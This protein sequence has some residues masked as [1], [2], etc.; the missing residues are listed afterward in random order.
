[1]VRSFVISRRYTRIG[2]VLFNTRAFKIF[3]FNSHY[4]KRGVIRAINGIRYP[5]GGTRLGNA[6]RYTWIHLFRTNRR[7]ARK[8]LFVLTDGKSQDRVG[9][10][11]SHLRRTGVEIH[12]MG[13]GRR[14]SVKQLRRVATDSRHI[15]TSGF[16]TMRNII[17]IIKKRICRGMLSFHQVLWSIICITTWKTL[18]QQS[19]M[20]R[21]KIHALQNRYSTKQD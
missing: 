21:H 3:G 2:A 14:Y 17:R 9:V 7:K 19:S 15:F 12:T 5:R 18:L 1:M 11:A 16:K 4:T 8:V 6:L 20:C 10:V 13:I